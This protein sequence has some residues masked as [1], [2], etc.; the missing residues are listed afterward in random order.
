MKQFLILCL[1][2]AACA[3]ESLFPTLP[4]TDT[5]RLLLPSDLTYQGAFRLPRDL[6]GSQYGFTYLEGAM[7]YSPAGDS[8]GLEDGYPGALTLA[9]HSA[10]RRVAQV[11]IPAP[12]ITKTYTS[13]P[14]ATV[15]QPFRA[16]GVMPPNS[17]PTV[18]GLEEAGGHTYVTMGDAYLPSQ[19]PEQQ[20]VM[21]WAG[22]DL[23]GQTPMRMISPRREDCFGDYLFSIPKA[24]ADRYAPGR[25]LLAGRHREGNLCGAGPF[26]AALNPLADPDTG[27]LSY[28]P[29][30]AYRV[31]ATPR[32]PAGSMDHS[33]FG[34]DIFKGGAW[35]ESGPKS[36]VFLTGHK[37][38]GLGDYG[39]RCGFQGFHD[40]LG[41]RPYAIFYDPAQL[42]EVAA[43][44]MATTAPQPYAGA[45]LNT[46]LMVPNSGPC[47]RR[48]IDA[49]AY[50]RA[51]NILYGTESSGDQPVVHVWRVKQYAVTPPPVDPPPP[52]HCEAPI[53]HDTVTV[54]RVDTLKQ[55]I[56]QRDTL[57]VADTVRI[58][59]L[60]IL[61]RIPK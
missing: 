53:V 33:S 20:R 37:G 26:L 25:A 22:L 43:G 4:G 57:V 50:D 60:E 47:A 11:S 12:V 1:I 48:H 28:T 3:Q 54:V 36:A 6:A 16:F 17:G 13:L 58:V 46:L 31:G 14:M 32:D 44:R 30:L 49:L 9:G 10:E 15:L 27:S 2:S 41:Y 5:S 59:P 7:T 34:G 24:W 55:I 42:G 51:R 45:D 19:R 18:M 40:S 21:A 8:A 38:L 61:I 23:A 56:T 29:L 39:N 35:L 52:P